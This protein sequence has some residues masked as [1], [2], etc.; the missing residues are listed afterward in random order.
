MDLTERCQSRKY[1]N[2]NNNTSTDDGNYDV[3]PVGGE[4][5]FAR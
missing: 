1:I 5:C 3:I 2:D 4:R